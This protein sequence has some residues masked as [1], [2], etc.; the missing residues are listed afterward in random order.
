MT[1]LS[2]LMATVGYL[3]LQWGFT[4][5]TLLEAIDRLGTKAPSVP[6]LHDW[7]AAHVVASGNDPAHMSRV[8]QVMEKVEPARLMRNA[9]SHGLRSA[10]ANPFAEEEPCVVC[11]TAEGTSITYT[12]R[13]IEA[14]IAS[15]ERLRADLD[16]LTEAA[17]RLKRLI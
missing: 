4:E 1:R 6:R 14:Q 16:G 15:L 11:R 9:V 5:D 10:S 12:Q 8:R 7:K 13:D 17:L 2:E 3:L